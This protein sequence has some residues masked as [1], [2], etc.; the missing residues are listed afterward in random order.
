MLRGVLP[1]GTVWK[2][3]NRKETWP[4][5]SLV[6]TS[7]ARS[8]Q[9]TSSVVQ[10]SWEHVPLIRCV[11]KGN[12]PLWYS[13]P[14]LITSVA[15]WCPMLCDPMNCSTPGFPVLHYHPEFAQIHVHWVGDA[16]QPSHPLLPPSAFAFNL[17]QHQ[18][19][20]QSV[21]LCIRWP[22]IR[23]LALP[24]FLPMNT[25]GWFP[26]GL[27]GLILL[28][29]GLSRDFSSTTIWKHQFFS[30]QPS[31]WSSFHGPIPV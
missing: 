29:K 26:L 10:F 15:K 13:S 12:S 8:S 31:L 4:Q 6:N 23:A 25:Q 14:K 7:S 22:N 9:L 19:L 1:K 20:F 24:S 30:T 5:R 11:E 18:A 2:R 17:S 28:S 21:S 3:G 27:T 16:I